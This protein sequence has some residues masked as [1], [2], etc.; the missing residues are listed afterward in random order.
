MCF[1]VT[2][3][4][5]KA[6]EADCNAR[7][8][9]YSEMMRNA[10]NAAAK[11][12]I[13][14]CSPCLAAVLCG[15]GNNGGDGFVIAARLMEKGFKVRVILIC[16]EPKTDCAREYF[17]MLPKNHIYMLSDN[18]QKCTA[19]VQ[20]AQLVVD[21]VFGTGFHGE[22]PEPAARIL[23]AAEHRPVR[24]AVDVPSGVNSDTGEFDPCCFK[25]TRTLVLAAFKK[26]LLAPKAM[27]LLGDFE[28]LDI[29]IY[30]SCFKEFEAMITSDGSRGVLPA[31]TRTS[32]KGTFGRLLNIAGS[33]NCSGAAIMSTRAALRSGAGLCTLAAPVST[34]KALAGSLVEN[35][36]LPLPET[37]DGF[38]AENA[39]EAI[40]EILPKMTAVSIGCGLGNSENTRKITEYVIRNADCPI[41]IDADG[42][43][44]IADNINVLKERTGDSGG[45]RET[46]ITPHPLEFSRISGLST[47]E[48]QADRIGA[49]KRF[50][51]EYGVVV[52]LKGAYSIIS[53]ARGD[54]VLVNP[55]GNAALAKGG[56]GDIL[57]GMIAAML[58]QGVTPYIAAASGA[59]CH[60]YAADL[61]AKTMFPAS[62]LAS[63]IIEALPRVYTQPV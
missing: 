15:A 7:F 51:A 3:A 46:V 38:I 58:A 5:M 21:C 14:E 62:I 12:I 55:T 20:N 60:G 48:I 9:S 40:A 31:R 13:A 30:G 63:D 27:E 47:D 2:S 24:V 17:E 42:I 28:T 22:L 44:S 56:S 57:T 54:E 37:E 33:L 16:G 6:A 26:G 61:L 25:P 1:I 29:G 18:E 32:H 50:A 34:V 11:R 36:F 41:I 53:D 35:T 45:W 10:G 19:F 4:Q 52:L 8:I 49:A 39:C 59:Y 43:N 23:T